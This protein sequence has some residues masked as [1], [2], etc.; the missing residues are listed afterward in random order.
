[1]V[2]NSACWG[3]AHV[4]T[5]IE[6]F[7]NYYAM[8]DHFNQ[9]REWVAMFAKRPWWSY[10][11]LYRNYPGGP[12]VHEGPLARGAAAARRWRTGAG[13]TSRCVVSEFGNWGLPDLDQL[14]AGYGGRE[15]WWFETGHDWGKGVVYPHGDRRA[16][17]H[18]RDAAR[19]R[20]A[21][22]R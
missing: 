1:M 2:D 22:R 8:P 11:H 20:H 18:L 7:H 19:L 17:Q 16:V 3:N 5:D 12:T 13:A 9:W 6:D 15:P 14:F 21:A 4:V 10:A